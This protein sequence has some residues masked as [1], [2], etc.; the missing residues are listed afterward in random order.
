MCLDTV[1]EFY[2]VLGSFFI[3]IYCH[4]NYMRIYIPNTN[5]F[6]S[7]FFCVFFSHSFLLKIMYEI[8][9]RLSRLL[10]SIQLECFDR[11]PIISI[12][13]INKQKGACMCVSVCIRELKTS[14]FQFISYNE[15]IDFL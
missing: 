6:H 14:Y 8:Q 10:C 12:V 15:H 7:L 11:I 1:D 13:Q 4:S 3:A 9:Y 2:S 5:T